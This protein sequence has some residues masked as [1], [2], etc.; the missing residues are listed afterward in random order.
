MPDICLDFNGPM[1]F[2]VLLT[3]SLAVAAPLSLEMVKGKHHSRPI[4][5]V[6]DT[7]RRCKRRQALPDATPPIGKIYPFSKMAVTFEPAMGF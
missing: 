1:Q 5:Y 7:A 2:P 6:L 4:N 3:T